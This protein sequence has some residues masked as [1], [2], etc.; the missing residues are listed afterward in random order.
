[1]I[2]TRQYVYLGMICC[3]V[4]LQCN[5]PTDAPAQSNIPDSFKNGPILNAFSQ[6]DSLTSHSE[7][8]EALQ[9]YQA[10]EDRLTSQ[11]ARG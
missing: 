10:I 8:S 9:A 7:F 11:R 6:A 5:Y 4:H 3:W 2:R 1:M